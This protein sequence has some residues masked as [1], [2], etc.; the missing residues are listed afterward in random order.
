VAIFNFNIT[1]IL[2]DINAGLLPVEFE[3]IHVEEWFR[4]H[5]YGSIN[6]H[7]LTVDVT[8]TILQAEIMAMVSGTIKRQ[9]QHF[10]T[11]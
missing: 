7:L 8:K 9:K 3:Q 10:V 4:T 1:R 2:E 11:G 6:E 5:G